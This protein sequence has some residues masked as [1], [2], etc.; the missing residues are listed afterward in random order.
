M[1]LLFCCLLIFSNLFCL[2][3]VASAKSMDGLTI[4]ITEVL[5]SGSMSVEVDN[6]SSK[7][8]RIWKESNSWGAAR[9]RVLLIRG[10]KLKTFFQ[11]PDQRFTRNVPGFDEIGA[12][13]HIEKK[14]DLNGG[15]WEG[16]DGMQISFEPGDT[17]IVVYDVPKEFGWSDSSIAEKVRKMEVWYGVIAA[18]IVFR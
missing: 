3:A 16:F 11:S 18:S 15:N 10:D 12:G 14:L 8:V 13:G 1:K 2:F 6:T 5:P 7:P 9:W 4:K 17:I